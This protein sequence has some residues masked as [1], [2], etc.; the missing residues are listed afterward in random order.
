[1]GPEGINEEYE[2]YFKFVLPWTVYQTRGRRNT[3]SL[4]KKN[5]TLS[6]NSTRTSCYFQKWT[7]TSLNTQEYKP[8]LVRVNRNNTL[9]NQTHTICRSW[10]VR[11]KSLT[12]KFN[13]VKEIREFIVM[14]RSKRLAKLNKPIYKKLKYN[15][16]K[17]VLW[18]MKFKTHRKT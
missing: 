8:T 9:Q 3:N 10:T 18:H 11:K 15:I 5:K 7:A 6:E 14:Q 16:M 1:M 13:M 12:S 4:E 17:W 2:T